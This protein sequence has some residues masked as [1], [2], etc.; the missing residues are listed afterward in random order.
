MQR[1]KIYDQLPEGAANAVSTRELVSRL[2][3]RSDRELRMAI[4]QERESGL[5]ILSTTRNGGGYFRPS[6]GEAGQQEIAAFIATLHSRAINTLKA[7]KAARAAL[8]VVDGQL[9]LEECRE[10]G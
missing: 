7:L 5:L 3:F 9:F 8:N 4:A 2:G 10:A 6:Q 1:K